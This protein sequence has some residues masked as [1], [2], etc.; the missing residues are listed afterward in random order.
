MGAAPEAGLFSP[1][2]AQTA[3]VRNVSTE[4]GRPRPRPAPPAI[5]GELPVRLLLP[6]GFLCLAA[7]LWAAFRIMR[8]L[9]VDR[10]R[11][12]EGSLEIP[13]R[14]GSL[15]GGKVVSL[16]ELR[17]RKRAAELAAEEEGRGAAEARKEEL[18]PPEDV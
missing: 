11:G 5:L 13:E 18:S 15:S 2:L 7:V 1:V 3:V 17:M 8:I 6:V 16:A 4:V 10:H 9:L 12:A 14:A